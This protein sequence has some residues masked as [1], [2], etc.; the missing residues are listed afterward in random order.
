MAAAAFPACSSARLII[1]TINSALVIRGIQPY[2]T[3]I[4]TGVLLILA[5]VF[6][7]VMTTAVTSRLTTT[8]DQS[9][10]AT[11]GGATRRDRAT[12]P[13]SPTLELR[14][15]E[16]HYGFVKAL[17]DIDFHVDAGEVVALVGDN[18]A[19]KSTLLK[20]MSGAHRPTHGT[21]SVR[22]VAHD[23]HSPRAAAEAGIQMVYQDL[24]L[25]D[26]ADIATNL[27][28]GRE[29]LASPTARLVRVPR[30]EGDAATRPTA[31]CA[32]SA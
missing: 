25:V 15:I 1:A 23:F 29:P 17:D 21:V 13:R 4:I 8:A 20:V 32:L 3:T 28:L 27:T 18:G 31:S 12:D 5:L 26:A 7:K 24:A 19:G 6:D 2:W 30:Q 16:K 11:G 14:G 9:V 10:H 22:G